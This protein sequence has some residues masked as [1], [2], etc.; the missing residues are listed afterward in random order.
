MHAILDFDRRRLLFDLALGSLL[1]AISFLTAISLEISERPGYQEIAVPPGPIWFLMA[2]PGAAVFVRRIWPIAALIIGTTGTIAVWV[3]GLP[4]V[5]L[6][7]IVLLFTAVVEGRKPIGM[8]AAITASIIMTLFTGLGVTMDDVPF[9]I[10]G[11]VA[12]TCVASI[13]FGAHTASRQELLAETEQHLVQARAHAEAIEA[14]IV[15]AERNRIAR[16][17]HDVV[18]HGLSVIVVQS[19]GAQ[20]V[21]DRQPEAARHALIQVE[22]PLARPW[23]RCVRSSESCGQ[24]MRRRY[25]RTPAWRLSTNWP[26]IS[27]RADY[28][29]HSRSNPIGDLRTWRSMPPCTESSRNPSRT[30]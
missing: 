7:A 19:G 6:A 5:T 17:L 20:R 14:N 27:P 29:L 3:S 16:E 10:V 18:A 15:V 25:V 23:P 2:A 26:T 22:Q 13:S 12:L 30:Y 11:L 28:P 8:R 9:Y 21:L 1:I 24:T 4:D